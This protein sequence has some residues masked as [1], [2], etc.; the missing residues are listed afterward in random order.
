MVKVKVLSNRRCGAALSGVGYIPIPSVAD[1]F[2]DTL[3]LEKEEAWAVAAKPCDCDPRVKD[4]PDNLP[5]I[6]AKRYETE[7]QL[8]RL[9]HAIVRA[10][11]IDWNCGEAGTNPMDTDVVLHHFNGDLFVSL[12]GHKRCD[13]SCSLFAAVEGL[14]QYLDTH[15]C[16]LCFP[17][18]SFLPSVLAEHFYDVLLDE[19]EAFED[20]TYDD[21]VGTITLCHYGAPSE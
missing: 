16:G 20:P 5:V 17:K 19:E 15:N 8:L 21:A 3:G 1:D 14:K 10:M 11:S 12:H 4:T 9:F 18:P 7:K 6:A 2:V 13:K